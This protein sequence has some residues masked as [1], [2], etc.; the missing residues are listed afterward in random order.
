MAE[1][2][3]VGLRADVESATKVPDFPMIAGRAR[4]VRIRDRVGAVAAVLAA[5][6]ILVPIGV[7]SVLAQ[8]RNGPQPLVNMTGPPPGPNTE[9]AGPVSA[10]VLAVAG[11]ARESLY[12]AI[13]VCQ[14]V[15]GRSRCSLQVTTVGLSASQQRPPLAVDQLRTQPYETLTSVTLTPLTPGYL[16]LSGLVGLS[17]LL[18]VRVDLGGGSTDVVVEPGVAPGTVPG[19]RLVQLRPRGPLY[20]G[21]QGDDRVY[22]LPGSGPPVRDPVVVTTIEPTHGW[23]LTGRSPDT[24]DMVVAVSHDR[25]A[26]WSTRPLWLNSTR[27]EPVVASYDGRT[28]YVFSQTATGVVQR[29]TVDGGR[30]WADVPAVLPWPALPSGATV[31]SRRLGAIVRPDGSLLLWLEDSPVAVFL[32][33]LD[34]GS[35]FTPTAGP[36][37]PVV[38]VSDGFASVSDPPKVSG[39]GRSWATLPALSYRSA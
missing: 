30:T 1:P 4:R 32:E 19:D 26:T 3:F 23:W 27:F 34:S 29:R 37:G 39:D 9:S 7:V 18:Q 38:P 2:D 13:D 25:G 15:N 21:R 20:V 10:T 8:P 36:G 33:S 14:I 11:M 16:L 22:P 17:D 24:E 5:L 28:A 6:G 12:A 35:T 31:V